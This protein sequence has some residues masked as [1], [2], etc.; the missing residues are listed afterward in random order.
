MIGAC[1]MTCHLRVIVV[2]V[3][4]N[5]GPHSH[6]HKLQLVACAN[7]ATQIIWHA[8]DSLQVDPNLPEH[9]YVKVTYNKTLL[10]PA[11]GEPSMRPYIYD[12]NSGHKITNP[13]GFLFMV[14]DAKAD[15]TRPALPEEWEHADV[16]DAEGLS[17][18][19]VWHK[20]KVLHDIIHH[21]MRDAPS[22]QRDQWKAMKEFHDL[23]TTSDSVPPLPI[24]LRAG[25][26][27]VVH[28][29]LSSHY[30]T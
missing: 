2:S 28:S 24:S 30:V 26:R 23:Y 25:V 5:V 20:N 13:K 16:G 6:S 4:C 29:M 22:S 11:P 14:H 10:P 27:L 9:G 12:E 8:F 15:L 3:L 17:R 7:R 1:H 18:G 21:R 19:D